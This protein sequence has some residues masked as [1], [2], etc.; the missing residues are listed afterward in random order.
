MRCEFWAPLAARV[1]VVV[2]GVPSTLPADPHRPGWVVGDVAGLC[3]EGRYDIVVDGQVVRPDPLARRLPDGLGGAGQIWDSA[4]YRWSDDD[5][6]GRRLGSGA[7]LY[8][9]HVGTFTDEGTLDSAAARLSYLAGL[10]ISHIELMPLAAFDGDHGWGYD[11]VAID[12]VHEPYGGPDALCRFVD[13]AHGVGIAVVLDTVQNHLGPSGN[14]WEMFG[15]FLTATHQTPWG[16]A[17][18]LDAPGSDDVRVILLQSARRWICDFHLDGLRLDAVQELRDHRALEFLAEL[19]GTLAALSQELARPL[20]LIAE[21]D[22][23]DPRTVTPVSR[24]GL[25][26]TAQWDDDVHHA[27]HWLL[28]GETSGYYADFGSCEA[29]AATLEHGFRHDGRWSSFRGR[30]HGAP[31]DW[32]VTDPWRL[33]ASLQTHDQVGNRARGERLSQLTDIDSCAVGAALLLTLPYTPLLFM[34]EEWAAA[35]PWQFFAS[36]PDPALGRAV[37][38]GRRTE[39]A[40]HGWASADVPDPQSPQTFSSS[41]LDWHEVQIDPHVLV[42]DWYRSLLALRSRE[43]GLGPGRAGAGATAAGLRCSWEADLEG[44]PRWFMVTRGEWRTV[45][46]LSGEPVDIDLGAALDSMAAV[47]GSC[48]PRDHTSSEFLHFQDRGVAV[49]RCLGG[50]GT[51]SP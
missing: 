16:D 41:V 39:F 5:W 50:S 29:V 26:M 43:P 36:H 40:S 44:R 11:G 6:A 27:L 49:V 12:A 51:T 28:T 32:T 2:E 33:V 8:E 9:L 7:V 21:S 3:H 47:W 30:S 24:N 38:Q 20:A 14:S 42:L 10:G 23:N 15:P 31:I 35:T 46:N 4:T 34:G 13:A 25:G 37:S 18:N 1:Q 48:V 45:A 17:V 22:R 19:S